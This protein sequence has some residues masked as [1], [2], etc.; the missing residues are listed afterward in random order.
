P[1]CESK[2]PGRPPASRLPATGYRPPATGYRLPACYRLP[3]T[4]YRLA[5]WVALNDRLP[6]APAGAARGTGAPAPAGRATGRARTTRTH[7]RHGQ[8]GGR[9]P[10]ARNAPG[11]SCRA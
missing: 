10:R 5:G 4:T 6:A 7:R 3:P 11:G 9:D 2:R 8:A 1:P